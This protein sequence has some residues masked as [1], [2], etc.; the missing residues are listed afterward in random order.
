LPSTRFFPGKL[1]IRN[2]N[3]LEIRA[4]FHGDPEWI[5]INQIKTS[6]RVFIYSEASLSE[7]EVSLLKQKAQDLRLQVQFRSVNHAKIR[8]A[9][10]LPLA[11]ISH[12]SRDKAEVARAIA[13]GLQGMLCPVWYD[14]FSLKVGA[15]LRESIEGGLKKCKKCILILSPNF[16]SNGGWTKKEFN[17]IFTREVLE[18]RQLVLPVWFGVTEQSVYEYSQVY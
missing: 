18:E 17:S 2:T 8:S 16:L 9:D 4:Q 5:S 13:F 15:S 1:E 6:T 12:D 3:P 7:Y 10:E 11:F 14:E